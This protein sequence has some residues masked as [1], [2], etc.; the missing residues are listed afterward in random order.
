MTKVRTLLR[1]RRTGRRSDGTRSLDGTSFE[2]G[3]PARII[4]FPQRSD[5]VVQQLLSSK[6]AAQYL[7]VNDKTLRRL[8]GEGKI[9]G[10]RLDPSDPKSE[11]RFDLSVLASYFTTQCWANLKEPLRSQVQE[12]FGRF[13][14]AQPAAKFAASSPALKMPIPRT[15]TG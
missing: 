8:A 12:E 2:R 3:K 15:N 9:P 7:G 13:Q 4:P 14:P 11:W 10:S 1:L 5:P 6:E